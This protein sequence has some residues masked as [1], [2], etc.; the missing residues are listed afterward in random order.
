MGKK[1]SNKA[2]TTAAI[3]TSGLSAEVIAEMQESESPADPEAAEKLA[4]EIEAA[5]TEA[6]NEYAERAAAEKE[7]AEKLA[8]EIEAAETEAEK[9]YAER[10]VAEKP[11]EDP[12][13]KKVIWP[14]GHTRCPRC[15]VDDTEAYST[16]GV[17]QS[18]RC[19][20]AICRKNYQVIGKMA[21][22]GKK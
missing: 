17:K 5:E 15:G 20:R 4:A 12:P 3:E 9:E 21:K 6:K 22:S 18:R 16:K 1:K 13:G 8:V 10:A 11:V 14:A 19:R 2:S 7:A